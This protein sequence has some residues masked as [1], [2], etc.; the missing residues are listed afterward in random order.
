MSE[1]TIRAAYSVWPTYN[2]IL[3]ELVG[4]LTPDQLAIRPSPERWPLWATIGHLACQRVFWLGDFAG[5]PGTEDT[6]FLDAAYHCPG[7]D[8]LETI[9]SP[10][11]LVAALLS[12]FRMVETCLDT[13]TVDSLKDEIRR[14]EFG[15][16]WVHTRGAVIQ[17][18]FSHD[19]WHCGQVS[20]TLGINALPRLEIWA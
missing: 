18:V 1:Q 10:H 3:T 11:D 8:D 7:D 15:P 19:M 5:V 14:P 17:R 4:S 6:P 12:T 2:R 9:L 13:W 16:D 20:Q